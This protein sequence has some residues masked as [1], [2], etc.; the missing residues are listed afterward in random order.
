MK[1]ATTALTPVE[2]TAIPARILPAPTVVGFDHAEVYRPQEDSWLLIDVLRERGLAAG[3]H[4]ADLCTGSGVIAYECSIL[5]ARSVLAVDSSAAAVEA[6]RR[7]CADALSPVTVEHADV[8]DLLDCGF[9]DGGFLDGGSLDG[10]HPR[11][12]T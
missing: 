7:R 11:V 4:A 8:S 3:A 1:P 9:L 12:S 6:T 2:K 5:G 10:G